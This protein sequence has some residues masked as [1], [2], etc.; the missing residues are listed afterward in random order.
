MQSLTAN[1]KGTNRRSVK[2]IFG[3]NGEI[4]VKK[5]MKFMENFDILVINGEITGAKM[6]ILHGKSQFL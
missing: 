3:S 6:G 5:G 1:K 4:S 2:W